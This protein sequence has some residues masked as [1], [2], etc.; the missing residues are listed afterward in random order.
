MKVLFLTGKLQNYRVP[1][2]N[3]IGKSKDIDLTVAH[4]SKK[5]CSGTENFIEIN[6]DEKFFGKFSF[7]KGSLVD[8]CNEYD[9]VV[10]MFYLQKISFMNL[11]L[12]KKRKFKLIYW[13]IGVKASQKS[14][15]NKKTLLNHVRYYFARRADAVI[16]YTDYPINQY[17]SHGVDRNKLFV[18]NNTVEISNTLL[19]EVEKKSIIFVGTLNKS[20]KIFVLLNAYSLARNVQPEVP[21]LEIVGG[22]EDFE[23]VENWVK[24]KGLGEKIKVHGPIYDEARLEE[25]FRRAIACISPGQAGLSVLKSMGYGV[26]FIT[27]SDAITGGERFNIQHNVNGLLYQ[28]DSELEKI[29]LDIAEDTKRYIEMGANARD[30]Y[31]KYRTPKMMAQGFADAV[32]YVSSRRFTC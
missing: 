6:I 14:Q 28:D 29:L 8:L 4:S 22:G 31:Y 16:F 26:P 25:I 13:G 11:A 5:I 18:M 17:V 15:Y 30:Y 9:V 32:G 20:K 12:S 2:F 23:A 3:I 1:I 7:H 10:A 24:S 21:D 27:R 19:D